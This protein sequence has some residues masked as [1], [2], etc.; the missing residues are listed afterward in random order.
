MNQTI[1]G[2]F[3]SKLYNKIYFFNSHF[4]NAKI[5]IESKQYQVLLLEEDNLI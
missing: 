5:Q 3:I 2:T 4:L 1:V